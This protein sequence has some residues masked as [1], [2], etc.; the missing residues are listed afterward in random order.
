MMTIGKT[1]HDVAEQLV[2]DYAD[3]YE[4]SEADTR[5]K[6]IDAVLHD[7]LGWPRVAVSC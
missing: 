6:V 3:S 7:V 1:A 2:R 4:L 5:H